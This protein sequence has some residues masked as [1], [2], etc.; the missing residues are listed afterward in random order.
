MNSELA[1][2]LLN[3]LFSNAIRHTP[4]GGQLLVNLEVAQLTIRNTA[5][6]G[7]L[8]ESRL[9]NRFYKGGQSSDQ[10]GLGLSIVKQICDVSGFRVAYHF[11]NQL[12]QFTLTF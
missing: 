5:A 7:P 2:I 3:N 12:H 8:D 4:V 6:N 1:D 11:A 9:F 10:H